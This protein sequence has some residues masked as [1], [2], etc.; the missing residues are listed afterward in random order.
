MNSLQIGFLIFLL[1]PVILSFIVDVVTFKSKKASL[2]ITW[3]EAIL[4][5]YMLEMIILALAA[6]FVM[7]GKA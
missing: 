6:A 5:L 3:P 4:P 7:M 1:L 2:W